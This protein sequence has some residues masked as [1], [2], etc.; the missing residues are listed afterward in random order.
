MI[1]CDATAGIGHTNEKRKTA[2]WTDRREGWN[3]YLDEQTDDAEEIMIQ[4]HKI[5][6]VKSEKNDRLRDKVSGRLA[7]EFRGLYEFTK[8]ERRRIFVPISAR[9]NSFQQA[10]MLT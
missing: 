9:F 5:E 10:C 3:S 7:L 6:K 1:F 4:I 8:K 2:G